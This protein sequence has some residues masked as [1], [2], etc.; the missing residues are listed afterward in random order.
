M[1]LSLIFFSTQ[2]HEITRPPR[3]KEK[4]HS[5]DSWRAGI[6]TSY[7]MSPDI[8]APSL[9][10]A[11]TSSYEALGCHTRRSNKS[12][13]S[14][15]ASTKRGQF[16]YLEAEATLRVNVPAIVKVFQLTLELFKSTVA[17]ISTVLFTFE[18]QGP[19]LNRLLPQLQI[20]TKN[21][22]EMPENLLN[23]LTFHVTASKK[24]F[25]YKPISSTRDFQSGLGLFLSRNKPLQ[26]E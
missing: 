18:Q 1:A 3:S 5:R 6:S 16:S 10:S 17:L 11:A 26:T 2:L 21:P 8:A 14:T 9:H 15:R 13:Q 7:S 20:I 12:I 22:V 19:F 23:I 25:T 24:E 4:I